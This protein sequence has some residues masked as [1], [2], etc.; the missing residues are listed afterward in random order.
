[1]R[2]ISGIPLKDRQEY[3]LVGVS[4]GLQD[5]F[6]EQPKRNYN[7]GLENESKA[8]YYVGKRLVKGN[9]AF[10]D[11]MPSWWKQYVNKR[12]HPLSTAT[13]F[14]VAALSMRMLST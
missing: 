8:I 4:G 6:P 2:A 12:H 14:P 7:H 9:K 3:L 5:R 1:M 13:F 11:A 10:L